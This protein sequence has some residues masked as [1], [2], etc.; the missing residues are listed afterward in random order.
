MAA[1]VVAAVHI[2]IAVVVVVVVVVAAFDAF[3][4]VAVGADVVGVD[5]LLHSPFDGLHI[6]SDG[7]SNTDWNNGNTMSSSI[8]VVVVVVAVDGMD[9]VADIGT[10][11]IHRK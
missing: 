8:A 2:A 4:T 11:D 3:E 7:H 1:A 10:A 6:A 5:V 9:M